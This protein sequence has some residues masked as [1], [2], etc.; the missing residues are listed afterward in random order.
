MAKLSEKEKKVLKALIEGIPLTPQPFK[1][2]AE[3]ISLSE[4][5][6]IEI[7]KKLLEKKIIRRLGATIRHNLIGYSSNALVAW[8]IPEEEIDKIGKFLAK[9]PFI[10][11]CYVRKPLVDW[12]YNLYT[13]FHAKDEESL[14]KLIHEVAQEINCKNYEILITEKEIERKHAE[15]QL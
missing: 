4:E 8:K 2:I 13:M 9:K 3:K 1:E 7:T 10:S 15:Y 14:L 11:H 12:P 6:V 5:E